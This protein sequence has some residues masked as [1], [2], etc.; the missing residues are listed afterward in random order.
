[1]GIFDSLK[2]ILERAF[3][4]RP[5]SLKHAPGIKQGQEQHAADAINAVTSTAIDAALI[6]AP[7]ITENALHIHPNSLKGVPGVHDP[8]AAAEVVN[9][10]IENVLAS[11]HDSQ[12]ETATL[13]VQKADAGP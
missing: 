2:K 4:I 9:S 3:H 13:P 11:S 10:H 1:M 5:A 7:A 6:A 8:Q 12:S